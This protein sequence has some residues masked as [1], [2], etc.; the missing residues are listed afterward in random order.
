MYLYSTA[1]AGRLAQTSFAKAAAV[2][3]SSLPQTGGGSG[4]PM[5]PLA[6]LTL[7]AA[8]AIGAGRFL[9]RLLKR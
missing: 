7:L 2:S 1:K 9:P 3:P 8:I 4:S 5:S 6:P